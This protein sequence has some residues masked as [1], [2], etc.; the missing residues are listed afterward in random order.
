MGLCTSEP[1][2][3][4]GEKEKFKLNKKVQGKYCWGIILIIERTLFRNA[5][6]SPGTPARHPPG[7]LESQLGP[8]QSVQSVSQLNSAGKEI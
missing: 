8:F 2:F 5:L 4:E 6:Y 3:Q 7:T 1:G